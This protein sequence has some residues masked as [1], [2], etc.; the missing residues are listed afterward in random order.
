MPPTGIEKEVERCLKKGGIFFYGHSTHITE[1]L[2]DSFELLSADIYPKISFNGRI[3]GYKIDLAKLISYYPEELPSMIPPSP[4]ILANMAELYLKEINS[5]YQN[6]LGIS[7]IYN[8]LPL[9]PNFKV[10][11]KR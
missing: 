10:W 8:F 3:Q 7:Y 2:S 1:K 11:M 4:L 9:I 6:R 5:E